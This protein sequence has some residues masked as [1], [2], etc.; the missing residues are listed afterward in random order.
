MATSRPS[1]QAACDGSTGWGAAAARAQH[2]V[3]EDR[4]PGGVLVAAYRKAR[5]QRAHAAVRRQH[6]E[7]PAAGVVGRGLHQHLSLVQAQQPAFGPV[8][9]I[10]G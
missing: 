3:L 5:P 8:V 6:L 10:D 7:R 1:T 2:G 9:D 4:D